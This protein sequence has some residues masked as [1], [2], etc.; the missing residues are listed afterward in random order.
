MIMNTTDLQLKK[1]LK[2]WVAKQPLPVNGRARLLG[3]A[4]F[5]KTKR[6]AKPTPFEFVNKPA[7]LLSWAMVYSMDRGVP[8]LRL[9]S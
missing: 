9:V 4:A 5:V 3:E 6:V 7:D 1:S 8:T 2:N